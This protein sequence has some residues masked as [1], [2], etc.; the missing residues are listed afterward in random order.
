M[1]WLKRISS[2]ILAGCMTI[3]LL[4]QYA[5][6]T[7]EPASLPEIKYFNDFSENKTNFAGATGYLTLKDSGDEL[8]GQS[9]E[10]TPVKELSFIN[11][12]T[13]MTDSK[14]YS[15]SF[16]LKAGQTDHPLNIFT[17]E[18]GSVR[19]AAM[20]YDVKGNL[21]INSKAGSFTNASGNYSSNTN[22]YP[23]YVGTEWTNVT[24]H[25]HPAG[26]NTT[27][28]WYINGEFIVTSVASN[29]T[30]GKE[31][32]GGMSTLHFGTTQSGTGISDTAVTYDGD[33]YFLVDNY[34]IEYLDD[35]FAYARL[36]TEVGTS[37]TVL[38]VTFSESLDA[39]IT[40]DDVEIINTENGGKINIS[41]ITGSSDRFGRVN[42]E[43]DEA[44]E[45][46]TEYCICFTGNI[47]ADSGRKLFSNR[48]YF[49]PAG[50]L[51]VECPEITKSILNTDGDCED[52]PLGE[53]EGL[54]PVG[55]W[56]KYLICDWKYDI[57][58]VNIGT[59]DMPN[60]A[61][62]FSP[63]HT[64]TQF[65]R[66]ETTGKEGAAFIP[67][68]QEETIVWSA[69]LMRK[70]LTR[71]Y[72]LT[73]IMGKN[74][75]GSAGV[76][77]FF[78]DSYGNFVFLNGSGDWWSTDDKDVANGE[79]Y[80]SKQ[81]AYQAGIKAE[82]WVNVTAV[83]NSKNETVTYFVNKEYAGTANWPSNRKGQGYNYFSGMRIEPTGYQDGRTMYFDNYKLGYSG[84]SSNNKVV[85]F[86]LADR[87]GNTYGPLDDSVSLDVR[88]LEVE[89]STDIGTV[90]ETMFT[91]T[92][93]EGT[94]VALSDVYAAGKKAIL[95][96]DECLTK[97]MQYTLN[98]DGVKTS[99][100]EEIRGYENKFKTTNN[101]EFIITGFVIED[102]DGNTVS[103]ISDI[104]AGDSLFLNVS[105]LNTTDE[106]VYLNAGLTAYNN[107]VL[108]ADKLSEIEVDANSRDTVVNIEITIEDTE[109]LYI[110]AT[111]TD[112]GKKPIM[113][114]I[115]LG[116]MTI[117][118]KDDWTISFED[119]TEANKKVY[120]EISSPSG[121]IPNI[122]YRGQV[123]SGEDGKFTVFVR[124]FDDPEVENDAKSGMYQMFRVDEDGNAGTMSVRF[125]NLNE[126][127]KIIE[128]INNASQNQDEDSAIDAICNIL[129]DQSNRDALGI[130]ED[131]IE[132]TELKDVSGLVY[133]YTKE[134]LVSAADAITV[135]NK[136]FCIT[137]II[138]GNIENLFENADVL[139][140]DTSEIADFY[141]KSYVT[142][143]LR[144][145]VT[146]Q[147]V[148]TDV[149]E[150]SEFYEKLT[151]R[152]V[153]A[154]VEN[155]DGEDN[156]I[157][158]MKEF[159]DKIGITSNGNIKA[160]RAVM[161][162]SYNSYTELKEA[163]ETANSTSGNGS[164]G[165]GHS[166]S[167]GGSG[168][169]SAVT[170]PSENGNNE[171][172]QIPYPI[173]SDIEGVPWA[174]DAITRLAE[175]QIINGKGDYK[176]CPDDMVTRAELAK[177]IVMA[178][179]YDIESDSEAGFIDV[180]D[181]A[182]D[183]VNIAFSNGVINGY[184]E[185]RFGGND[186][187]TRQ[188]MA[189][190]I[191]RAAVNSG[192]EFVAESS[193]V[194]SDSAE[195]EDYAKEAVHALYNTGIVNG[196]GNGAFAPLL[197]ATRA[198]AAKIIYNTIIL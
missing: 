144:K 141:E 59:D 166:S 18:S 19:V 70:E 136:A 154:V 2:I 54:N 162:N 159:H 196:V 160:Y 101:G 143:K 84:A 169:S 110:I 112:K 61:I 81:T 10:I 48:L 174:S 152:F 165:G 85:S 130:T 50:V 133:N 192:M 156:L 157:E 67:D 179:E 182:R 93:T 108:S 99:D 114:S 178:F 46:Y 55:N 168:I 183:Y 47:K 32:T 135:I 26:Y 184:D 6:G 164:S 91:L 13:P 51:S 175:M 170:V 52:L 145:A 37:T 95:T 45:A 106:I 49:T 3:V 129:K 40:T 78:F 35:E 33:E 122:V 125:V 87:F 8:Y 39:E 161:Y 139:E 194:F 105:A 24:M 185:N 60:T 77:Y 38:P 97:N 29:V 76:A 36:N 187:I 171:N 66:M 186:F 53:L 172:L 28:D 189:T 193:N 75:F 4:P 180:P 134:N 131:N 96:V 119:T 127:E 158:I 147:L 65:M 153:L 191:Y 137:K 80:S 149:H 109:N 83:I 63:D 86:R 16:E 89:F 34:K 120:A 117:D 43:I 104:S 107:A 74:G 176:F 64:S 151:E 15:L 94:S 115:E 42:I 31:F 71:S 190:M 44:L 11:V 124:L 5:F 41:N 111:L 14:D 181:W 27:I 121:S 167:G 56:A 88:R 148:G 58:A 113:P 140:L 9:L 150:F 197:N 23:V 20:N 57:S 126:T 163:F 116:N 188:D 155:P 22:L 30:A 132:E 195:I 128:E 138:S 62:K 102:S 79:V 73:F 173:F 1:R 146:K 21:V 90:D 12:S 92:D 98:V 100:G 123:L 177:M 198:E 142:E 103:D 17:Q 7:A 82:D 118:A 72:P 68:T 25:F 69:D